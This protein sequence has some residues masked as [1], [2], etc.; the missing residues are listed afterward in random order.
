M[1]ANEAARAKPKQPAYDPQSEIIPPRHLRLVT[2]PVTVWR[3]R[4]AGKFP[5][6]IRLSVGRIGWR[7][8]D[9][10][11]WLAERQAAV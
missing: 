3:L 11:K 8:S 9:L 10:D 1:N 4:R 2:G 6:P 7:R 5:E